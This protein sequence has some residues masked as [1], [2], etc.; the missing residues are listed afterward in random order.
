MIRERTLKFFTNISK[1]S[2][3]T[4]RVYMSRFGF[5]KIFVK[6]KV[7]YICTDE[8]IKEFRDF[9]KIIKEKRGNVYKRKNRKENKRSRI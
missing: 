1:M 6:K 7:L 8:Q 4:T 3:I 9:I 2:D 5:K